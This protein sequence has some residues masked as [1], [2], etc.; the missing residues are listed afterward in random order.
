MCVPACLG[1]QGVEKI[2]EVDLT[3]WEKAGLEK[4]VTN[5]RRNLKNAATLL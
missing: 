4:S 3:R 1:S 5:I 2:V